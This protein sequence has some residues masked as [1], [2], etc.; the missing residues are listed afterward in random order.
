M[1]DG[2]TGFAGFYC[3]GPALAAVLNGLVDAVIVSEKRDRRLWRDGAGRTE[4]FKKG[5]R[6]PTAE[7]AETAEMK[8][9]PVRVTPFS[10]CALRVLCGK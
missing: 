7:A 10:L 4:D 5:E 8:H 2:I 9:K 1:F 3:H 6:H